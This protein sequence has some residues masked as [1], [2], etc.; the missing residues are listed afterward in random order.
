MCCPKD[1]ARLLLNKSS[2]RVAILF[3]ATQSRP[4]VQL[5]LIGS[6]QKRTDRGDSRY[7]HD[8]A[9]MN[10]QEF[11]RAQTALQVGESFSHNVLLLAA[12]EHDIV[13]G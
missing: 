12:V 9:A 3:S 8:P 11:I 1:I 6:T 13:V 2:N 4:V 7:I 5:Q 10:S